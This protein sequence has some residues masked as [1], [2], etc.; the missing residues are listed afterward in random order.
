[1]RRLLFA[2]LL[3]ASLVL[4]VS[5]AVAAPPDDGVTALGGPSSLVLTQRQ[6]DRY[7]LTAKQVRQIDKAS[8]WAQKEGATD[9]R[10]C[11]SGNN[12]QLRNDTGR[13]GAYQLTATQ[14]RTLDG[15]QIAASADRAAKWA[16]DWKAW[17]LWKR[18][19]WQKLDCPTQ[20]WMSWIYQNS[21]QSTIAELLIPGTH[22][23]GSSK[24]SV[25]EPCTTELI[26][27]APSDY[28]IASGLNPCGTAALAKAQDENLG[29]Q[30]RGGVRYLDL[31]VGVPAD[32][33]IAAP[34]PNAPDPDSVPL[35]LH[36]EF[37]SQPLINGL[38]QILKFAAKH[39]SE[40]VILDF[41]HVTLP[42]DPAIAK[43]YRNALD[44]IL[45]NSDLARTGET[46]CSRAWTK[47]KIGVN[48]HNL[49]TRVPLQR[50]WDVNRNLI[51]LFKPDAVP[52]RGCYRNRDA[53]LLSLWPNTDDPKQSKNDNLGYLKT[54]R[55]SLDNPSGCIDGNDNW[56]GIFVSQLQLSFQFE[57]QIECVVNGGPLC[58]LF[59]YSQLVNDDIAD[60][61]RKWRFKRELP[62]NIAMVDFYEES[63]PSIVRELIKLNW[64]L[65]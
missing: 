35:V 26:A 58:S 33:V 4:S 3:A 38:R 52:D 43:Y 60:Y 19:A 29:A 62:V 18:S 13:G 34:Q 63:D 9:S 24:I 1:M 65:A 49:G 59:A 20:D 56:C 51:V 61:V 6:I 32:E 5:A 28:E 46:V 44:R 23:A 37:V 53:A 30:L 57:Q 16:Q 11:R 55:D 8:V 50:A 12:Y 21:P 40:Q 7:D 48:D 45:R 47:N 14:W 25:E 15:R 39:P 27:G 64:R 2:P 22:D 41:Q 10:K 17:Q 54:R 36:H 42:S 31:R